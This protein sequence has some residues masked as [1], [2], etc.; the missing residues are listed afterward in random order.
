MSAFRSFLFIILFLISSG[1][2]TTRGL[3]E[4][5]SDPYPVVQKG[6]T[7]TRYADP[8]N[9]VS[10]EVKTIKKT[11]PVKNL[12]IYYP[13]LFPGGLPVR[14]GD[15]EEYLRVQGKNAYKV[16]FKPTMIRKRKRYTEG[17]PIPPGWVKGKMEDPDGG[18]TAEILYGPV[19]PKQLVLYL[20]EG[21]TMVYNIVLTAE[22]GE[23]ES[24]KQ[25]FEQF[26][27]NDIAYK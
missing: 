9:S 27:Q 1:C 6:K 4:I 26:V 8:D 15:T 24:A 3:N 13:T 22:D 10:I 12:A 25:K 23:I 17:E 11:N 18:K 14:A 5:K 20:I 16:T 21:D 2:I 7:E 19:I